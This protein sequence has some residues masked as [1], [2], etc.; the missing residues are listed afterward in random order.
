MLDKRY[1]PWDYRMT[2]NKLL[3]LVKNIGNMEQEGTGFYVDSESEMITILAYLN[4]GETTNTTEAMREQIDRA[5]AQ[6]ESRHLRMRD[7]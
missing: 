6:L 1:G 2:P 5:V 3:E 4:Y 7:E